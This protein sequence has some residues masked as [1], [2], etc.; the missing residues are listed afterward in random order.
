MDSALES[1]PQQTHPIPLHDHQH[2]RLS[3][4]DAIN[5]PEATESGP[6]TDEYLVRTVSGY[7]SAREE[8]GV[9]GMETV[10]ESPTS[11]VIGQHDVEKGVVDVKLVTWK[12]SSVNPPPARAPPRLTLV[13]L[14]Y[15]YFLDR[16]TIQKTLETGQRP[17]NGEFAYTY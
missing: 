15:F 10:A 16:L 8:E 13:H 17:S 3:G 7:I 6:Q 14:F 2:R 1:S 4:F 12:V 9:T 11:T 5:Y